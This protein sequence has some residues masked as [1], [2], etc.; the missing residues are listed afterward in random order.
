LITLPNYSL[1]I[2]S[3]LTLGG[4]CCSTDR[5]YFAASHIHRYRLSIYLCVSQRHEVVPSARLDLIA[6]SMGVL[7]FVAC[8]FEDIP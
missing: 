8:E 6:P 7:R 1:S 4:K 2:T 3:S 5:W